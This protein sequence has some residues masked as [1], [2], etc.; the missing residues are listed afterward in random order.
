MTNDN[1]DKP[2]ARYMC[3]HCATRWRGER[4]RDLIPCPKC[5]RYSLVGVDRDPATDGRR[6]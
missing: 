5:G 4:T 6:R 2:Q 1:D 3:G